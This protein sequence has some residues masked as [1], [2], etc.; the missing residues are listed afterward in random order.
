MVKYYNIPYLPKYSHRCKNYYNHFWMLGSPRITCRLTC[1]GGIWKSPV[2]SVAFS[3][4]MSNLHMIFVQGHA[5]L[6]RFS[7]NDGKLIINKIRCSVMENSELL[8]S[9]T[10]LWNAAEQRGRTYN[11]LTGI[12]SH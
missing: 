6:F 4:I 8:L 7:Q 12:E 3:I 9:Y 2:K 11:F 10:I 5:F 1:T